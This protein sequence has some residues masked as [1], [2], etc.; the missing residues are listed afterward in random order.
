MIGNSK[1]FLKLKSTYVKSAA[2]FALQSARDQMR[3]GREPQPQL[4]TPKINI[5]RARVAKR[6]GFT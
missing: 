1:I 6:M 3:K 4:E 5:W 2:S